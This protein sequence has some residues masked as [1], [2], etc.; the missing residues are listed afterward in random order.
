[1]YAE[2]PAR[3][4]LPQAGPLLL[5]RE[6]RVPGVRIDSGV[7]EGSEISIYY[8][9]L[10]AKVITTAE[11]RDLAIAKLSSAL[12]DFPVLGVRTN[13][14]FLLRILHHPQFAGGAIDTAFLDRQAGALAESADPMPEFVRAAANSH[15]SSGGDRRANVAGRDAREGWDPWNR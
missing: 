3:D 13:I 6:P 14:P 12:R 1:M 9:P 7:A 4:F 8:D 10:I 5:Y 11:T 15:L 2:D